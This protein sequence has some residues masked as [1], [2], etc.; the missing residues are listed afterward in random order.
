MRNKQIWTQGQGIDNR[1]WFPSYDLQD[2]KAIFEMNISFPKQYSLLASGEL[3]GKEIEG[4]N[5]Q[6]HYKTKHPM[7]SY[8]V[9]LAG[10][11]YGVVDSFNGKEGDRKLVSDSSRNINFQYW[12][13]SGK[14]DYVKS[15]YINTEEIMSFFEDEIGVEYPWSKYAQIPVSDF[16][17]GAMENTEATVFSDAYFCNDTSFVDRNYIS[18]NAHEM[19]H[20]WFG[21]ALTC[22]SSKHHWLHEGFATYYQ[23]RAIEQFLGND[24]FLWEKKLYR[25]MVLE[26][27]KID[28]L[29]LTHPKAGTERFYYKG[30][31]VLMMLEQ[32]LGEVDFKRAITKYTE[33]NLYG[34]VDTETLKSSFENT[35]GID[36]TR[37]FNQ[38]IYS[39]GEPKIKVKYFEKGRNRG[40][41]IK[42]EGKIFNVDIPLVLIRKNRVEEVIFNLN[43]EIDT[44]YFDKKIDFFEVDPNIESLVKYKV[45]KPVKFWKSQVVEGSTSYSRW[46]AVNEIAGILDVTDKQKLKLFS[47]IDFE[48][49]DYRVL[50]E[51]YSQLN[52]S[53]F[54]L[55][56]EL[57][58]KVLK[59]N[60]VELIKEI[61]SQTKTIKISERDVFENYLNKKSYLVIAGSLDL[62]CENF[63]DKSK[64]YLKATRDIYGATIPFVKLS[65]LRNAVIYGEYSDT[66]TYK[67]AN[68]LVEFTSNSYG[69]NTRLLALNGVLEIKYFNRQLLLNLINGSTSFNHHLVGP[70]RQVMNE[71]YKVDRFRNE[72][73][74]I[75]AEEKLT[76][77]EYKYLAKLLDE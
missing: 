60:N 67:F 33:D 37:F 63:P 53:E 64:T 77:E 4:D 65:W 36:L 48:N 74:L 9:M 35:L 18:V 51:I 62:L 32:K 21:D 30:A 1:S 47:K 12:Y 16:K 27:S 41:E 23:L 40:V 25:D 49:E 70:Y 57:K 17:H 69:F 75:L 45:S 19:A 24:D 52:I 7:S 10:G 71:L 2:E 68:E 56:V 42:Q 6:W 39:N 13:Y 5:I 8:L 11:E 20:Q 29:P 26:K 50:S 31:F 38:W 15:T 14:E 44:L 46:L 66:E 55:A 22:A 34:I 59:I 54:D 61:I 73:K 72:L 3:V 76:E 43:S 28:S 58:N